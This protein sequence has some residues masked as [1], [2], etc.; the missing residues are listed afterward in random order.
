MQRIY[1]DNNATT[2]LDPA[3]CEEMLPYL[4]ERFGN[5]SSGHRFGEITNLALEEA[6]DQV[7]SLI[8]C[9]ANRIFFTSGGTE[10]NNTAIWSSVS[11]Y[12][13]KKHIITSAVE[14][15]SV[16][17]PLEFLEKNFG[18]TVEILP[19]D[20]QGGLDLGVLA[21]AIRDETVLVS[22]MA[23]N[24]ES[25]VVWPLQEIGAL[26][27]E[28]KVLFHC[29]AVQLVGKEPVNVVE[30]PVDYLAIAAHKLHGPKGSGALYVK[31]TAPLASLIMG[32]SQEL[33]HRA[34]TENVAGIVGFGKACQLAEQG[35][36]NYKTEVR[37][38]RDMLQG[39]I[40]S[41]I[42]DVIVNGS[43][44]PRLA[45]TL[46]TSFKNCASGAMVQEL[47]EKGIAV[48]AHS[49][50]HSGDLDPSH[51]LRAMKI[52]ETHI[53]GTLRISLSRFNTEQEVDE[54]LNILPRVVAKS[55]LG[56]AV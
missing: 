34:G 43:G 56:M 19:V 55:R 11:A 27:R 51:V 45:N 50:C 20:D 15:A 39:R 3:V 47:D 5:P 53:H 32:A 42:D 8:N 10:S 18:Y 37:K 2:P 13:E 33:G 22:L 6:R 4:S 49:A 54:F 28:R 46:N 38:L 1:F 41:E 25:G 40:T 16:L 44:Q 23:A 52:P 36:A 48:S 12:P 29:D 26:C 7:A 9:Q 17:T 30:I 35:M 21:G 31:R 24:N 14:H